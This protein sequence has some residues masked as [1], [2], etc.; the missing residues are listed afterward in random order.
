MAA[1]AVTPIPARSPANLGHDRCSS[2]CG[3]PAEPKPD[4]NT[5]VVANL[6][7]WTACSVFALR[8]S[9]V[10][11]AVCMLVWLSL[12]PVIETGEQTVLRRAIPFERQ[13]RVFGFAQ[14]VENAASPLTAFTIAP[15]ADRVVIPFMTTGAGA[16]GIGDWFGTGTDRGLALIFTVAG[17]LGVATTAV[18]WQ[19]RS[20]RASRTDRD[21]V[22]PVGRVR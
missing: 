17:L 1:R 4:E 12:M 14:L 15:L 10:L 16:T 5:L 11:L 21:F 20:Y 13:G 2:G 18:L 19:S 3:T 6:V 22:V 9:I 8:S 7:N